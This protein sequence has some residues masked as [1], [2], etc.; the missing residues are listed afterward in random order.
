M[1][2]I[3]VQGI[4]DFNQFTVVVWDLLFSPESDNIVVLEGVT[5]VVYDV[6]DNLDSNANGIT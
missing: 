5:G 4:E 3:G 2:Y 1:V 6:S